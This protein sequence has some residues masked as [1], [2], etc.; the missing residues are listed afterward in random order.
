MEGYQVQT[1]CEEEAQ[2]Q[3]WFCLWT[4]RRVISPPAN[5]VAATAETLHEQLLVTRDQLAATQAALQHAEQHTQHTGT[6]HAQ[7][8]DA[9]ALAQAQQQVQRLTEAAAAAAAASRATAFAHVAS[10]PSTSRGSSPVRWPGDIPPP[11]PGNSPVPL[12]SSEESPARVGAEGGGH[13]HLDSTR[14]GRSSDQ[15]QRQ[16][17]GH[18]QRQSSDQQQRQSSDQQQRQS[19]DQQQRQSSDQQQQQQ[20]PERELARTHIESVEL[21]RL[22]GELSLMQAGLAASAQKLKAEAG[23][24]EAADRMASAALAQ[25]RSLETR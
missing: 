23:A 15:Q 16:S 14:A 19:S 3:I 7:Q 13:G 20:Q 25:L 4:A 12:S 8:A 9:R 10:R 1:D 5:E 18:Q 21:R 6:A 11:P 2:T 24:R 22:G 17:S